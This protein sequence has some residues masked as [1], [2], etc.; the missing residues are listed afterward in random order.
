VFTEHCSLVFG[1][2]LFLFKKV[3]RLSRD[4]F[5]GYR[6]EFCGFKAVGFTSIGHRSFPSYEKMVALSAFGRL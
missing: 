2:C 5:Y 4:F 3:A 6:R 1:R